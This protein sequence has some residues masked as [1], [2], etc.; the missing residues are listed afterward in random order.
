MLVHGNV[1]QGEATQLAAAVQSAVEA[2]PRPQGVTLTR[3]PAAD[4]VEDTVIHLPPAA[5]SG[6]TLCLPSKNS[7]EKNSALEVYLQCGMDRL[8]A[9]RDRACADL[10]EQ[11]MYQPCFD[12]LRTKQQLGYTVHCG[13]RV[14]GGA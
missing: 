5:G 6:S 4:R 9:P 10:L 12:E 11:A 2:T 8:E 13:G 1:D 7:E 3:L 14:T